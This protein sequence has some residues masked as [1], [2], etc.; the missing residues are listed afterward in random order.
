MNAIPVRGTPLQPL[1]PTCLALRA[2]EASSSRA[3]EEW[4]LLEAP[5]S[6]R[7]KR[8]PERTQNAHRTTPTR[9]VAE[10]DS[11]ASQALAVCGHVD[12]L[13]KGYQVFKTDD[14]PHWPGASFNTD[15]VLD[16]AHQ[17]LAFLQASAAEGHR[18]PPLQP[19]GASDWRL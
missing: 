19:I 17:L 6:A 12:G 10:I 8:R 14:L 13:V 5:R 18:P 9:R 4:L 15:A 1:Q 2:E 16:N 7:S 3:W 11:C